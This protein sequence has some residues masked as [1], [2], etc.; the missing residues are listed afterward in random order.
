MTFEEDNSAFEDWLREQCAHIGCEVVEADL[1]YKHDQMTVD[2]FVFLRAT[3]FRW[4]K[5]I[6]TLLP[7]SRRRRRCSRSVTP[8]SKILVLG[9][10]TRADWS[11][12]STIS[13]KQL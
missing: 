13:M 3:F 1:E 7:E 9:G 8:T 6:E 12:V 5:R 10:T 11:G 4:A 2:A